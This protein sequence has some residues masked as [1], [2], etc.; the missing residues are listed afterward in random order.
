M[1]RRPPRSTLFPYTTLFRSEVLG[2]A[3]DVGVEIAS[4]DV[5]DDADDQPADDRARHRVHAAQDDHREDL[6]ADQRELDIDAE[7]VAPH[8]APERR[9]DAGHRPREREVALDVDP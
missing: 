4:G 8:D 9:D 1:L 3:P 5:L 2:A 6:E 7:Q